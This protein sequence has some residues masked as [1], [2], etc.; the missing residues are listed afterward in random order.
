MADNGPSDQLAAQTSDSNSKYVIQSHPSLH[1]TLPGHRDCQTRWTTT[2]EG[3]L[4]SVSLS[5]YIQPADATDKDSFDQ[6][7]IADVRREPADSRVRDCDFV[8]IA[9]LQLAKNVHGVFVG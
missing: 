7:I 6:L 2:P 3:T 8:N 4:P 5:I 9:P 1:S